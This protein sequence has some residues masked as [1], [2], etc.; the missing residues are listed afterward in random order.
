[1]TLALIKINDG[2]HHP[3]S[4]TLTLQVE[5]LQNQPHAGDFVFLKDNYYTVHA[6]PIKI[7]RQLSAGNQ[8]ELTLYFPAMDWTWGWIEERIKGS[9][10]TAFCGISL[11]AYHLM[12]L[13]DRLAYFFS[14]VSFLGNERLSRYIQSNYR[15]ANKIVSKDRAG[16]VGL[17]KL[18]GLPIA[19]PGFG[20]P[21]DD[22]GLSAIFIGQ[23]HIRDF[24]QGS[25]STLEFN[26]DG[27]LYFFGTVVQ[28]DDYYSFGDMLVKYSDKVD[29]TEE[30]ELPDDLLPYGSFP[31]LDMMTAEEIDIP[32]P[33]SSL[34]TGSDMTEEEKNTYFYLQDILAQYGYVNS[35]KFLGHPHEIQRCV[36][37]EAE[38]KHKKLLWF[39]EDYPEEEE[40]VVRIMNAQV[41]HCRD[42]RLL[43]E[44]DGNVFTELSNM[45]KPVNEYM[46]GRYYVMIRQND[47]DAMRFDNTVTIYQAT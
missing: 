37:L 4:E 29:G 27:I 32:S 13:D 36:L 31:E 15:F 47:L 26:K 21:K 9:D 24:N 16:D 1:M 5:Y 3:T 8:Y 41:E 10:N 20:F 17:T 12:N 38:L 43:L 44:F 14:I 42:W 22:D 2:Q 25:R 40:E 11:E 6:Y 18:G 19:A 46:D 30:I 7:I 33:N 35:I 23:I 28:E 45:E 34:W 39:G